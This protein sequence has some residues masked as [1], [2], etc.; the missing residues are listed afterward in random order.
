MCRLFVSV[1][2]QGP[3]FGEQDGRVCLGGSCSVD[4]R[5]QGEKETWDEA[6]EMH[7]RHNSDILYDVADCVAWDDQRKG[8][9]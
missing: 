1:E 3:D 8:A 6:G 7:G 5:D 9:R 4:Q 2:C